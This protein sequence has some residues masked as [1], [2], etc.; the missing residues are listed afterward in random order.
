MNR[1]T[2]SKPRSVAL[3]LAFICACAVAQSASAGGT[4][5]YVDVVASGAAPDELQAEVSGRA[6][7]LGVAVEDIICEG[8]RLGRYWTQLGGERIAPFTCPIGQA[9][10]EIEAA[11]TFIDET[12]QPVPA[13][14]DN[15]HELATAIRY[16]DVTWT[17]K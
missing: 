6:A 12:G 10:L 5:A 14:A 13:N 11:P 2:L 9:T 16:S 15:A 17:W 8:G 7:D 4:I 3:G 1:A